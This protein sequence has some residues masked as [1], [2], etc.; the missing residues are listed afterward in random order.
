MSAQNA[1]YGALTEYRLT[2]ESPHSHECAMYEDLNGRDVWRRF[3]W[4]DLHLTWSETSVTFTGSER[5]GQYNTLRHWA[6]TKEQ[7]IR[8]VRLEKRQ[9]PLPSDGWEPA[10]NDGSGAITGEHRE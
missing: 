9:V 5:F 10:H 8:N 6:E 1:D 3:D 7:P 2:W 4:S